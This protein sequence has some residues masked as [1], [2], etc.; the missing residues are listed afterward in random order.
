M[1]TN[2]YDEYGA[3]N[4]VVNYEGKFPVTLGTGVSGEPNVMKTVNNIVCFLTDYSFDSTYTAGDPII[5]LPT[6]CVPSMYRCAFPSY[7]DDGVGTVDSCMVV[8]NTSGEISTLPQMADGYTLYLCGLVFSMA[9]A[10]Y[11]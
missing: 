8:V 1:P 5:T 2:P 7:Y 9:N 3:P 4:A 6:E 11:V 10:Y